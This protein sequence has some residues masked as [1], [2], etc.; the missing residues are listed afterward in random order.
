MRLSA[1]LALAAAA[2]AAC[3]PEP[4]GLRNAETPIS[5][6]VAFDPARFAD[7]WHVVA[8]YGGEARCGPLTETWVRTGQARFDVTGTRCGPNGARAFMEA[9]SVTGP[10]RIT[11]GAEQ[12]WV[13][14]VDADYRVAVIG[15]PSGQFARVLSRTPG[16]R[17]DLMRAARDVL[18]FN[19]YDPASLSPV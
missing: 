10:G 9:A 4:Q 2:L 13:L 16:V 8:A 5:S 3:A 6:A 1:S 15:T 11:R 14:W 19:G 17:E 18:R 7:V 12:L